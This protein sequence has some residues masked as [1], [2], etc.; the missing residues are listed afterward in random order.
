[1]WRW[2]WSPPLCWRHAISRPRIS[3]NLTRAALKAAPVIADLSSWLADVAGKAGI[4]WEPLF[5]APERPNARS[6]C[7]RP[8]FPTARLAEMIE[9]IW[10]LEINPARPSERWVSLPIE[11]GSCRARAALRR[12][13]PK[14]TVGDSLM[15]RDA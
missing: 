12:S 1:M 7:K 2:C 14:L 15:L 6:R 13:S 4:A 9:I 5:D 11:N 10:S 8:S 3:A